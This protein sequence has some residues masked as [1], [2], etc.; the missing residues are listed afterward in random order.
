MWRLCGD[1]V[2]TSADTWQDY[3][4]MPFG[5]TSAHARLTLPPGVKVEGYIAWNGGTV[6]DPE[7]EVPTLPLRF[8][9]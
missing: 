9:N 4:Y 8:S 6:Y 3:A 5:N 1:L 7:D 2:E